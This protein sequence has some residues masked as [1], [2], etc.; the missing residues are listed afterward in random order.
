MMKLRMMCLV[1]LW[2]PVCAAQTT[3]NGSSLVYHSTGSSS[4]TAWTLGSDGYLGTYI[5]VASPGNVTIGVN[6]TGTPAGGV[7]QLLS[8]VIARKAR[9]FDV[10]SAGGTTSNTF[11]LPAGTFFVRTQLDNDLA[12]TTRQVTLNSLTVAG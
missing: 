11:A 12:S 2:A 9:G 10:T 7:K 1:L 8:V 5:T 6:A 4:G 3:L